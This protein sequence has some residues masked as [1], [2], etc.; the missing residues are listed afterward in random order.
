MV[1]IFPTKKDL[2]AAQKKIACISLYP[3]IDRVFLENA[4]RGREVFIIEI[5]NILDTAIKNSGANAQLHKLLLVE[6][7]GNF[8]E[9][10]GDKS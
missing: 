2:M 1:I 3:G 4:A 10:F 7:P 9:Y 6:T 8:A 5:W